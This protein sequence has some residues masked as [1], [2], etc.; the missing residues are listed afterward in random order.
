MHSSVGGSYMEEEEDDL[1]EGGS[2]LSMKK[3]LRDA[4]RTLNQ[5]RAELNAGKLKLQQAQQQLK[6]AQEEMKVKQVQL[7]QGEKQL[8]EKEKS[9]Q[10]A[11]KQ[12]SQG[13]RRLDKSKQYFTQ[14]G[15]SCET[16]KDPCASVNCEHGGQ[17][18]GG[19]CDCP[20]GFS[21]ELCQINPCMN[22]LCE[23]G[24]TCSNGVCSCVS[25][26]VGQFCQT[27][28]EFKV[29]TDVCFG[30]VQGLG[31]FKVPASGT[32]A[33][34][35]LVHKSGQ[36]HANVRNKR[37][38]P[39]KWGIDGADQSSIAVYIIDDENNIVFPNKTNAGFG[40]FIH[41]NWYKLK[42]NTADGATLTFNGAANVMEGQ[43]LRIV[44]S[45]VYRLLV[46]QSDGT[47]DNAGAVCCD[48][49]IKYSAGAMH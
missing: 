43:T 6:A 32:L 40:G 37:H 24:G 41:N 7:D 15:D 47:K 20:E 12:L 33:S 48:V 1:Y 42:G 49:F 10:L 34:V 39:S 31:A 17:C 11:M 4:E 9:L 27:P 45:E 23:H 29:G 28:G 3:K 25:G 2:E 13:R 5:K 16:M 8:S 35:Q 14:H 19:V 26:Y 22:V 18:I 46:G 36:T 38:R 21:G 30:A 44:F